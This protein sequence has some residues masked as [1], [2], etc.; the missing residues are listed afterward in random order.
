MPMMDPN[1]ARDAAAEARMRACEHELDEQ[2]RTCVKCGT[3]L[4]PAPVE[5]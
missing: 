5:T 2:H 4:V 1:R 3:A